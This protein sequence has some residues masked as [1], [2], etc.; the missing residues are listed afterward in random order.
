MLKIMKAHLLDSK[1]VFR[2]IEQPERIDKIKEN[3]KKQLEKL[4]AKKNQK[5]KITLF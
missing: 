1:R 5:Y 3:H 4:K 2:G